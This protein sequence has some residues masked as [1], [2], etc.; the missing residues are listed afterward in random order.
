[1]FFN[2]I[3]YQNLCVCLGLKNES[4]PLHFL[5]NCYGTT[6][7]MFIIPRLLFTSEPRDFITMQLAV[8]NTKEEFIIRSK[9]MSLLITT[10]YILTNQTQPFQ[11]NLMFEGHFMCLL[12]KHLPKNALSLLCWT[13]KTE[14]TFHLLSG[15]TGVN[16]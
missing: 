5:A 13:T 11:L 10:M 6:I 14:L 7:L 8:S 2:K 4:Q 16:W 9:T 1:M 3:V 12:P 15:S